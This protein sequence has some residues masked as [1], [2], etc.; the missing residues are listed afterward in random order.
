MNSTLH[1]HAISRFD[2]YFHFLSNFYPVDVCLPDEHDL[3]PRRLYRSVEHAYQAGK[4][5][6]Q[7]QRLLIHSQ[8][9]AAMAK[10]AGRACILRSDWETQKLPL[11]H[12]LLRQKFAD[13]MLCSRLLAT[14]DRHLVEGNNWG[15]EF[16]GVCKGQGQN[17]LGKLLMQ[18]RTEVKSCLS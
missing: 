9:S 10:H 16:W 11:M 12:A 18:V 13:P 2:G 8:R 3:V 5:L 1:L 17:H 7:P 15:D 6:D 14:C 4:T